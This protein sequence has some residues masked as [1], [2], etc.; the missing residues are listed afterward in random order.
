[1]VS[2][3]NLTDT[4]LAP[5]SRFFNQQHY[6]TSLFFSITLW[7]RLPA[8]LA[9]VNKCGAYTC[10]PGLV[11]GAVDKLSWPITGHGNHAQGQTHAAKTGIKDI[12]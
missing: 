11:Q 7:P 5:T 8:L 6:D 2:S 10:L 3:T 4:S 9:G 1:L 12:Y